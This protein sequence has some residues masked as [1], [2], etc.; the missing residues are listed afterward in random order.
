MSC[1]T[2]GSLD[3][4]QGAALKTNLEDLG[5]ASRRE[6]MNNLPGLL[7]LE[8]ILAERCVHHQEGP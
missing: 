8:S 6:E 1:L 2:A 5:G 3:K 7:E 4:E